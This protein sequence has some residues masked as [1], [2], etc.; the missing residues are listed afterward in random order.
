MG[1]PKS[2]RMIPSPPENYE[3]AVNQITAD[4][5]QL[6][7]RFKQ[8]A[9]YVT[10]NPTTVAM[11]SVNVLAEKCGVHPSVL[12]RFAQTFGY[13]GFKQM[14]IV[15]QSRLATAAPGYEER[16]NALE[17]EVQKTRDSGFQGVM[18]DL[19]VR[20]IATLQELMESISEASLAKA[21][22]LLNGAETIYVIGQLRS[23][24]IATFFR[25]VMTMLGKPVILL[26]CSGGLAPEVGKTIRKNDVLFVIS[27]RHYAK[28]SILVAEYAK[29]RLIP[30]I[31]MT[32]STL[33]PLAKDADVLF[34]VPE[35]EYSFSR[36]LAAPMCLAQSIALAMASLRDP[37]SDV[38]ESLKS[39][40]ELQKKHHH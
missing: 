11:D 4:Y 22:S 37:D 13:S 19:V 2:T 15:F 5:D 8:V 32:D 29:S 34:T 25:Y 33:S 23:E 36:S 28:E 26:D 21:A 16:V 39:V 20:D 38:S 31:G 10:Q 30:V 24:A 12:V 1:R 3:K 9:R 14:Q 6:S 35:S 27:F 7:E 40:T 17:K 18:Q